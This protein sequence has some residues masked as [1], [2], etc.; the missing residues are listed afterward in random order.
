MMAGNMTL[1]SELGAEGHVSVPEVTSSPPSSPV[2]RPPLS[3]M[4]QGLGFRV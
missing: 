1:V 4:R 3:D 2:P